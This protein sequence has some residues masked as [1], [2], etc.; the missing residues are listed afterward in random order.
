MKKA[1]QR[2]LIA[3]L[4]A[5]GVG[6]AVWG[7][8]RLSQALREA[9]AKK[10][11]ARGEELYRTGKV[12]EALEAWQTATEAVPRWVP[13]YF[14][15]AETL[16][17]M[18]AKDIA[19]QVLLR[20]HDANP[21]APHVVCRLAEAYALGEFLVEA[22][23]FANRA[24]TTEPTCFRSHS[25]YALAYRND[26]KVALEHLQKA[27]ELAP[28]DPEILM[29]LARTQAHAGAVEDAD[30]S[31]TL[32]VTLVPE[33]VDTYF[34]RGVVLTA[35]PSDRE[36]V[37]QAEQNLARAL[38]LAPDRWDIHAQIGILH[39]RLRRWR[40]AQAALEKAHALN[41]HAPAV[42]FQLATVYRQLNDA[43]APV[44][45]DRLQQLQTRTN[46]WQQL[47]REVAEHPEDRVRMMDAAQLS[48]QLGSYE[49]ARRLAEQVLE[50][51]PG[52]EKARQVLKQLQQPAAPGSDPH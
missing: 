35:R 8:P 22:R 25:A 15:M 39:T 18:E 48:V 21:K 3:A 19:V 28:K 6:G 10:H 1:N 26:N 34:L 46:R 36:A 52:N 41:P 45:W 17:E 14:R 7:I 23:E 13:P 29:R 37:R 11:Y 12:E 20:A 24:V 51:D 44:F 47:L 49:T 31:L 4:L 40:Q 43:R 5:A 32:L 16:T 38:G 42:I 30:R 2:G 27:H 33:N 9:P 50:K